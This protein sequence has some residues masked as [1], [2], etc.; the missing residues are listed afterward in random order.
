MRNR[1][2]VTVRGLIASFL[3]LAWSSPVW[4]LAQADTAKESGSWKGIAAGILFLIAIAFGSFMSP[5]RGHQD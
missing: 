4:A 2:S 3:V 1:F 5:K